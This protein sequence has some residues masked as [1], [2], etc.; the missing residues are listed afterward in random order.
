MARARSC[1]HVV[2]S[3]PSSVE[4]THVAN[5][6]GQGTRGDRAAD[7][8]RADH[9]PGPRLP[10]T[11]HC[12]PGLVPGA[13]SEGR[14]R[15]HSW[16]RLPAGGLRPDAGVLRPPRRRERPRAEDRVRAQRPGQ[17][18]GSAV[19]LERGEPGPAGSLARDRGDAGPRSNQRG[20]GPRAG[21]G[22]Q[23]RRLDRRRHAR[24]RAGPRP[25][26][27]AVGLQGGDGR[28]AR[29][30][31]HPGRRDPAPQPRHQPGR[32]GHL[33]RL[34]SPEPGNGVRDHGSADPLPPLRRARQQPGLVHD[35]PARD[36]GRVTDALPR[37][38][39]PDRVQPPPDRAAVGPHVHPALRRSRK[40]QHPAWRDHGREPGGRGHASAFLR[41]GEARRDLPGALLDVVERWRPDGALLPQ[42]DRDPVRD[43]SLHAHA[44]LLR[45]CRATGPAEP[46]RGSARG[47]RSHVPTHHLVSRSVGGRLVPLQ[48]RGGLHD[49][50]V[51]GGAGHRVSAAGAVAVQH[52]R[53]GA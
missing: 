19:H 37:V 49:H 13:P 42:H 15:L 16:R 41:G 24:H 33:D 10:L 22:R 17:A 46:V 52:L 1:A 36:P 51:H 30:A 14:L 6:V 35:S 34:V 25:D 43:E 29:N 45:S 53:H 11:R 8:Q 7:L 2:R 44:A 48:R 5:Q 23:G 28:V 4:R 27:V 18:H 31:T 21:R 47:V 26:D 32:P 12:R 40:P 50:R 9:E 39:S 3:H 38:V 20:R